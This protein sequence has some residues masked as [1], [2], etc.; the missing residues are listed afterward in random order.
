MPYADTFAMQAHLDEISRHVAQGAVAVLVLDQAGWHTTGKLLVPANI[1]LISLPPK[2]PE[3][4]PTENIWQYLRQT[5]LSIRVFDDYAAICDA[6]CNA[7]NKLIAETGRITS[8][9]TRDWAQIGQ[10][11]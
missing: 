10:H 1:A 5:W 11:Q 4:N 6:C 2:S 9:G 3:L 7:W 8:I